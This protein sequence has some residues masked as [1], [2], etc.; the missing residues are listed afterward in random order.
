MDVLCNIED[1]ALEHGDGEM[2]DGAQDELL[3]YLNTVNWSQP[4]VSAQDW[5]MNNK[6]WNQKSDNKN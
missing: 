2:M 6:I 4:C 5:F 1:E 3:N